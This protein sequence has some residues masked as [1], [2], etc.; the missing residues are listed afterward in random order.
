MGRTRVLLTTLLASAVVV[1]SAVAAFSYT[2]TSASTQAALSAQDRAEE[3]CRR[4]GVQASSV[5]WELCLS[6]VT[7]AYEW[8]EISLA[9]QLARVAGEAR[10][11][12]LPRAR[13]SVAYRACISREIDARSELLILGDDKIAAN[14]AEAR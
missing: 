2:P 14:V 9:Q 7:R 6:H 4:H 1:T 13:Q 10:E 12:C 8:G 3:S 11:D 5:A